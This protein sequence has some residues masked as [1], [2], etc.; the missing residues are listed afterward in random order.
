MM[1]PELRTGLK[2]RLDAARK[3]ADGDSND[4]EI[5]AWQEVGELVDVLLMLD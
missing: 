1:D 3:A 5:Q 2:T 4:E